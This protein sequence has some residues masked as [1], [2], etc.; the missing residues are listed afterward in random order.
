MN[1]D[2]I[3]SLCQVLK[4]FSAI[5]RNIRFLNPQPS[6]SHAQFFTSPGPASTPIEGVQIILTL[7]TL[8]LNIVL[9]SQNSFLSKGTLFTVLRPLLVLFFTYRI[10]Y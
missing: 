7:A 9:S 2:H 4:E 8:K 5:N 10:L 1:V 3:V 6:A